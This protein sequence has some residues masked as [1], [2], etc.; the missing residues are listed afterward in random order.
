MAI[1]KS[2][3]IDSS[4]PSLPGHFP[5]SPIVPGVVILEE[6]LD[7]I[8]QSL[9][10]PL[11]LCY[12]PSVKFHSPLRPDELLRLTFD[13]LPGHS[14]SFSCQIDSRLIVSGQFIFQPDFHISPSPL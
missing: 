2:L 1:E 4:H 5:G 11:M 12:V 13:I 8:G 9:D 6:V 10:E 3:I 7:L 14:V